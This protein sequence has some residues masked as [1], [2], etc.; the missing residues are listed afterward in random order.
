MTLINFL[1]EYGEAVEDEK[2]KQKNRPQN[3]KPTK[4]YRAKRHR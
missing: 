4:T 2:E 1:T 3:K